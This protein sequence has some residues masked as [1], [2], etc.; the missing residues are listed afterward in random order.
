MAIRRCWPPEA[1]ARQV[2]DA[3]AEADLLQLPARNRLGVG[4]L[5]VR[6][7]QRQHRLPQGRG[8]RQQVELLEHEPDRVVAQRGQ[9]VR[10]QRADIAAVDEQWSR[11]GTSSPPIRFIIVDLPDPDGPMMA[12]NSHAATPNETPSRARTVCSP[13]R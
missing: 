11:V 13:M 4:G 2:L 1:L 12:T 7:E 6:V 3:V 8:P 5:R 9:R 10:G